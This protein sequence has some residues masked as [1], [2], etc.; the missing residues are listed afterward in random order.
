MVAGLACAEAVEA[1][2]GLRPSLKWPNDLMLGG[3]KLAGVLTEAETLGEQLAFVVAGMGMN[4]NVDFTTQTEGD[5]QASAIGISQE[6]G[7]AVDRLALLN[8]LLRA[9]ERRYEEW[10]AGTSPL[11]EWSQHLETLGRRVTVS[12]GPLG[13]PAHE[14]TCDRQGEAIAVDEDGALIVRLDCGR[15]EHIRAGDVALCERG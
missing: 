13:A 14:G 11:G 4:V 15:I 8:R 1:E 2:T 3:R 9:L 12:S 5:L 10:Q 6:L 7:H